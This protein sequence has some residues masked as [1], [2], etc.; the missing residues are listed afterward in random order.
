ML[1]SISIFIALLSLLQHACA[2][3]VIVYPGW[4]GDN[5]HANGSVADTMGLQPG[6]ENM[7]LWPY[8]MQW[9]YPC[10][11]TASYETPALTN[12]EAVACR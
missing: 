10:E 11:C 8:G 3:T 4:R 9:T 12:I 7:D 1:P 2:H 5:L 6:G